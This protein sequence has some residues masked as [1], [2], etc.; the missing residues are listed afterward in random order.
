MG[1]SPCLHASSLDI[2][3][4]TY[5]NNDDFIYDDISDNIDG[6]CD[7]TL[8]DSIDV[9][10]DNANQGS[11]DQAKPCEAGRNDGCQVQVE[12]DPSSNV[13]IVWHRD[14]CGSTTGGC[15]ST[16]EAGKDRVSCNNDNCNT[17][18]PRSGGPPS[19]AIFF[20]TF[21][22]ITIFGRII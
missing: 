2:N 18:D 14:C 9:D 11:P 20:S 19:F 10:I 7:G 4:D 13:A 15:S 17:M 5:G 3:D 12:S 21:V 6:N 16:H 1:K 22:I 8:D